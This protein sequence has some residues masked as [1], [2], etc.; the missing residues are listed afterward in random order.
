LLGEIFIVLIFLFLFGGYEILFV[1][2]FSSLKYRAVCE[3]KWKNIAEW[4]WPQMKV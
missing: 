1:T 4:G 2:F 3:M